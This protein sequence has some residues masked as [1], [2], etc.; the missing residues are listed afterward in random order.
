MNFTVTKISNTIEGNCTIFNFEGSTT[1]CK[2]T[3][4]IYVFDRTKTLFYQ[5]LNQTSNEIRICNNSNL[6]KN[7]EFAKAQGVWMGETSD[8][9]KDFHSMSN[10]KN[11]LNHLK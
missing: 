5:L 8:H 11:F 3:H 7:I 10:S 9:M 1:K 2:H 6:F 4:N